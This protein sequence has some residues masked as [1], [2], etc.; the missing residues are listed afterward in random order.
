MGITIFNNTNRTNERS[1]KSS[2]KHFMATNPHSLQKDYFNIKT[3]SLFYIRKELKP[4]TIRFTIIHTEN[5]S[6]NKLFSCQT[7][8]DIKTNTI[9]LHGINKLVIKT[10]LNKRKK[11]KHY[12]YTNLIRTLKHLREFGRITVMRSQTKQLANKEF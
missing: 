2:R 10:Y 11:E 7:Q 5:Y 8:M 12:H 4:K 9:K 3:S 6:S 1:R